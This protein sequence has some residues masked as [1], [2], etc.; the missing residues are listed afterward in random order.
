MNLVW[1][2]A[3]L[4][5]SAAL[6][7][8]GI[9]LSERIPSQWR[10]AAA[11]LLAALFLLLFL[12]RIYHWTA[13]DILILLL[14]IAAGKVIGGIVKSR[15]ALA[16]FCITLA[17]MDLLSFYFGPAASLISNYRN[18]NR[19]ALQFLSLS[20]PLGGEVQPIMGI[21]DT[22]TLA[23]VYAA[24]IG[25]RVPA[26]RSFLIPLAGLSAALAVGL[27]VGG[28]CA[29]PFLAAAVILYLAVPARAAPGGK[30]I[31]GKI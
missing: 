10:I 11:L 28:I 6:I 2:F 15:Q 5:L 14:S 29:L 23:S 31:S 16:V 13:A 8:L 22:M 24:L 26:G 4:F 3:V 19:L 20:V 25:L 18:G 30:V 9:R 7:F 1:I 21:G 17:V 12:L 27:A